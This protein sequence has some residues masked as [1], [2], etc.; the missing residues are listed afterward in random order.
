ML[1]RETLY[2]AV[3][4]VDRFLTAL[5]DLP[6]ARLQLVGVTALHISCKSEVWK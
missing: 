6:K 5:A 4:Y 1:K 3:N 2:I